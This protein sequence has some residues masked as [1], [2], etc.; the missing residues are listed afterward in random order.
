MYISLNDQIVS[1]DYRPFLDKLSL[2]AIEL[3]PGFGLVTSLPDRDILSKEAQ[4]LLPSVMKFVKNCGVGKVVR[5]VPLSKSGGMMAD[6]FEKKSAEIY[7]ADVVCTM[8]DAEEI[9]DGVA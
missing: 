4:E 5:V 7:T 8:E 1:E 3:K 9:L 6:L 2:L